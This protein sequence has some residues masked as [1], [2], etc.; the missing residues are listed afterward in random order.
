[1]QSS[2]KRKDFANPFCRFIIISVGN[3]WVILMVLL[4]V[5]LNIGA[6]VTPLGKEPD[7]S[8]LD[9]FQNLWS[10]ESFRS[11]LKDIYC[12]RES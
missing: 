9:P 6:K 2:G 10:V 8:R 3:K 4:F 5:N 12:P 1:M 11:E 7:W